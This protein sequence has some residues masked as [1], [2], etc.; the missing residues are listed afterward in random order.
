MTALRV[1]AHARAHHEV[2]CSV[3]AHVRA[4]RVAARSVDARGRTRRLDET[5]AHATTPL[6]LDDER[7]GTI[8]AVA[9]P[10]LCPAVTCLLATSHRRLT[11]MG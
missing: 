5:L 3:D 10:R 1:G 11:R 9:D 4:H 6:P 2:I 8:V 7:S